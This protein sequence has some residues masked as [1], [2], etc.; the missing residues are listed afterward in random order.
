[1]KRENW[2]SGHKAK[3]GDMCRK[4]ISLSNAYRQKTL[5]NHP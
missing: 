3:I 1:M 5:G 4:H 2:Q